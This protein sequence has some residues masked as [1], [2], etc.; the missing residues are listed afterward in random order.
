MQIKLESSEECAAMSIIIDECESTNKQSKKE[1]QLIDVMKTAVASF[2]INNSFDY[3]GPM[4]CHRCK[5]TWVAIF[6]KN[7]SELECFD[8]HIMVRIP[9][10]QGRD[11][12]N[13]EEEE[14]GSFDWY[15]SIKDEFFKYLIMAS[16]H[17]D[18]NNIIKIG[19]IFPHIIHAKKNFSHEKNP[20][21]DAPIIKNKLMTGSNYNYES[22]IPIEKG[23]FFRY[24]YQ[25][26]DFVGNLSRTIIFS[27]FD[28][29]KL[30]E[31][32]YP[33]MVAAFEMGDWNSSPS[34]FVANTY[35][36]SNI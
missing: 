21:I 8:C 35:N 20:L 18:E 1:L 14:V 24:L 7:Q 3:I 27:D 32:Q 10:L 29:L 16:V 9:E 5:Y 25:S 15:R 4:E 36:S 30:I 11:M 22:L 19:N 33:Q 31:T 13:L 28:N 17:A 2:C 34:G 6:S 23:S 26:G 12:S